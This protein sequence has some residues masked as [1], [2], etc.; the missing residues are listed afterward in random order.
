MY[1]YKGIYGTKNKLLI[2]N[3]IIII[4]LV[5]KGCIWGVQIQF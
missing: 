2:G 4:T 1:K 5:A 3:V